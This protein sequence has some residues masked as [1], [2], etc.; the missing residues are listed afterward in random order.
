MKLDAFVAALPKV[1]LHVHLLGSADLA[2]V[3]DLA[4]LHR[5]RGVPTDRDELAAFYEFTDFAHFI[6]VYTAVNRLVT[7]GESVERLVTGLADSLV[8]NNVRYAEVT[9]TPLSHLKAGIDPAELAEALES[10]RL[11]ARRLGVEIAWVFDVSGDE[12][13]AGAMST[14]DW[15]LRHQPT[16]TVAFGLGGPEAGIPRASFRD[17]FAAAR[18]AGLRSVPHAG[19]TTGSDEVLSAL[20]ELG[21]DRI[22]HGIASADDPRLLARLAERGVPLEVCPTSNLRTN[23]VRSWAEHPLPRLLA[24]GVPVTLGTDDPGMFGT[25]LNREYLLCAT[26][27]GLTAT[28]LAAL[29][30][31]GIDAAFCPPATRHALHAELDAVLGTVPDA[32]RVTMPS[33]SE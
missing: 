32:R 22:G 4:L 31:A 26:H 25:T 18:T 33:R 30:R 19:E 20:T 27:L 2:T 12:G 23:A 5:D 3:A 16:G 28:G 6:D 24:A 11:A 17:A 7:T 1:E 21:A 8:A 10:G 29:A 13:P 9:V 15:V 14:I